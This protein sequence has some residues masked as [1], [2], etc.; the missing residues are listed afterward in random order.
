MS[1]AAPAG[2]GAGPAPSVPSARAVAGRAWRNGRVWLVVLVLLLAL[3]AA[4]L[5]RPPSTGQVLHPQSANPSGGQAVAEV[6]KGQGVRIHPADSLPA[7]LALVDRHPDAVLLFHDPRGILPEDGLDELAEATDPGRR[8]L[9]EPDQEQVRTLATGISVGPTASSP[10]RPL[11]ADCTL[12]MAQEAGRMTGEARLY[13]GGTGCFPGADPAAGTDV[14]RPAHALLRSDSS[15]WVV[16]SA[17]VYANA[18]AAEHGHP[19][20][21]LWTLGQAQDV[22]WYL[23][24]LAD[25]PS[26][27]A[28]TGPADLLPPWVE[29]VAWWLVICSLVLMLW[30]GRRHGPLTIEPLPVV[31]PASETAVGR[32]RLY[33]STGQ[34]QAAARALHRA[35]RLRLARLLRLGRGASPEAVTAEVAALTGQD[36]AAVAGLLDPTG[37]ASTA[38]L[39]DRARRLD[40]LEEAVHTALGSSSPR[41]PS[42]GPERTP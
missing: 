28:P 40:D 11:Q 31:V 6:L 8:V 34:V 9:V 16:G 7:A 4:P 23:P 12:P 41:P 32:A 18:S 10:D 22:V 36:P 38:D 33:Q 42:P 26:G 17:Q 21:A 25:V 30:R 35:T 15:T 2:V 20:I 39:V 1:T 24:S 19:V 27:K 29:P 14:G 5:L 37:V 3:A 13:R